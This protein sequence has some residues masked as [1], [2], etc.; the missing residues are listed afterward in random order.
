VTDF[1]AVHVHRD[2]QTTRPL[3]VNMLNPPLLLFI[4]HR[5]ND[6]PASLRLCTAA[7]HLVSS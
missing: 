1:V 3:E 6:A 7:A 2:P 5:L 4:E